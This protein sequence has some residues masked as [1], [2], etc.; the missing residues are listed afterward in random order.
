MGRRLTSSRIINRSGK[1]GCS[2]AHRVKKEKEKNQNCFC[3]GKRDKN[4]QK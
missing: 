4:D 3:E 2:T 1:K